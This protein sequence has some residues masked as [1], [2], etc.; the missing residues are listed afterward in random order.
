MMTN[1]QGKLEF[2]EVSLI[3]RMICSGELNQQ[4]IHSY[5]TRPERTI[6]QGRISEIAEGRRYAD[7]P[8][9]TEEDVERFLSQDHREYESV[10]KQFF[11]AE[12]LHE[13]RL[14]SFLRLKNGNSQILDIEESDDVEWKLSYNWNSRAEYGRVMASFANNRWRIPPVWYPSTDEEGHWNQP[15][16]VRT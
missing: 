1:Q 7:V 16:C 10:K 8:V 9:A 14:V 13:S 12:P 3:K 15:G 6:N 4:Q 11:R 5:F 2:W